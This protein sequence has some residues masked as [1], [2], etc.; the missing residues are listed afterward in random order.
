M[1]RKFNFVHNKKDTKKGVGNVYNN[2]YTES[3]EKNEL[4]DNGTKEKD[5]KKDMNEKVI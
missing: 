5:M 2:N 1:Q 4:N 3:N